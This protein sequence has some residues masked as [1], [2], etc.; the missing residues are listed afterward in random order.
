MPTPAPPLTRRA[1]R[2]ARPGFTLVELGVVLAILVITTALGIGALQEHL[3]RYHLVQAAKRLKSDVHRLQ[4][5]ATASGRQARLRL[6]AAPGACATPDD[7]G[8]GWV[9]ELGDASRGSTS[10][11]ILPPDVDPE[12]SAD[13]SEGTVVLSRDGNAEA[14]WT[15]LLPW[16][17]I[18][19]P[20]P[21][22]H[23]SIVINARG[24]LDNPPSDLDR[25]YIRLTLRNQNAAARG[26]DDEVM[27]LISA[28]GAVR[29]AAPA[30]E[31]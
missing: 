24:Y 11:D 9:L 28:A 30:A 22:D 29:L 31:R 8:G 1:P 5:L 13:D 21:T 18:A 19:G 25:G 26:V 23:D 20:S 4:A 17:T 10:W 3:P 14:P 16:G 15:C 6:L 12:A 27:L 2:R 7:W